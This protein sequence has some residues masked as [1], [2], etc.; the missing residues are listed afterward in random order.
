MACGVDATGPG[1]RFEELRQ[2][3]PSKQFVIFTVEN[4]EAYEG[5]RTRRGRLV[6]ESHGGGTG[7]RSAR[8]RRDRIRGLGGRRWWASPASLVEWCSTA[9]ASRGRRTRS[10]AV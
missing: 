2:R 9:R 6:F 7:P 4:L 5:I 3:V 10:R 8:S 1:R